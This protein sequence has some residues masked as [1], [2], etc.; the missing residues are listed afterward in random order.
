MRPYRQG[1]SGIV[2]ALRVTPN[3]RRDEICGVQIRDDGRSVLRVRVKAVPD[4]GQANK[5][6]IALL[7]KSLRLPKGAFSLVSG[8]SARL[9]SVAIAGEAAQI[10]AGLE[11]L[12]G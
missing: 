6:V 9:K 10:A 11:K 4:K 7:A 3:A 8:Q 1:K 2:V 5:A 12:L